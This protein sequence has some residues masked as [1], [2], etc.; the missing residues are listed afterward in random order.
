MLLVDRIA[1]PEMERWG[2]FMGRLTPPHLISE[3]QHLI[4]K[5]VVFQPGTEPGN[6]VWRSE[7]ERVDYVKCLMLYEKADQEF[8]EKIGVFMS[9]RMKKRNPP[10]VE[11]ILE[12]GYHANRLW[13]VPLQAAT[14]AKVVSALPELP[15]IDDK[16]GSVP[17]DV[18]HVVLKALPTP[19]PK[20]PLDS[21]ME[22]RDNPESKARIKRTKSWAIALARGEVDLHDV[23]T[24]VEVLMKDY[25]AYLDASNMQS[26][27]GRLEIILT[28]SPEVVNGLQEKGGKLNQPL[29]SVAHRKARL[30]ELERSA[31]GK[32]L[33]YIVERVHRVS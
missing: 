21:V 20:A 19:G 16:F 4:Q 31:P 6:I 14:H 25:R 23:E 7:A 3:L 32:E 2:Q 18:L 22:L 28:A 27:S 1:I 8:M 17:T 9:E 11:G 29:F 5:K 30:M 33:A 13:S 10:M 26:R 24:Q 15:L 12:H